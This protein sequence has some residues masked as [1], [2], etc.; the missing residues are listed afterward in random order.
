MKQ[1]VVSTPL[2]EIKETQNKKRSREQFEEGQKNAVHNQLGPYKKRKE[3]PVI[4]SETFIDK[5]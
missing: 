2:Q 3:M 4:C 5:F 1:I